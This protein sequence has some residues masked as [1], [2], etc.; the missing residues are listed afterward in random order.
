MKCKACAEDINLAARLCPKCGT[1][2]KLPFVPVTGTIL[3][4]LVALIAVFSFAL[5]SV[6]KVFFPP[7]ATPNVG[8]PTQTFAYDKLTLFLTNASEILVE[9]DR[10][11]P[12]R[13]TEGSFVA[14]DGAG[15]LAPVFLMDDNQARTLGLGSNRLVFDATLTNFEVEPIIQPLAGVLSCSWS[16]RDRN[17]MIEPTFRFRVA[18]IQDGKGF[19]FTFRDQWSTDT[20]LA[21]IQSTAP[22]R[23]VLQ[24][25]D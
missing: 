15:P 20:T 5:E 19:I 22:M 18:Y 13:P 16:M 25:L 7:R 8:F 17:G 23:G 6:S 14:S 9:P 21:D 10:H 3:S 1:H 12:C 2:Q 11:I 24:P 4:M